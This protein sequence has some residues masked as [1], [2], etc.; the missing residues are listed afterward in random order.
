MSTTEDRLRKVIADHLECDPAKVTRE[1]KFVDD[2]GADSLD[3]IEIVLAIEEEFD[4][5]LPDAEVTNIISFG[6]AL[7]AVTARVS[8]EA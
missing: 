4:I 5:E 3:G 6:A 2:L 8:A 7:D 1:A